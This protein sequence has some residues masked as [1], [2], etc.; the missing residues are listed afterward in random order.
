[1][2]FHGWIL[3]LNLSNLTKHNNRQCWMT[4]TKC[5][6]D[7]NESHI[8][9]TAIQQD[10]LHFVFANSS[11]ENKIFPLTSKEIVEAQ[12]KEKIKAK[13]K[14]ESILIENISVLCK[15]GKPVIPN[16]LQHCTVS[17]YHNYL[18]YPG[19]THLKEM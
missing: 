15:N 13:S 9:S 16:S 18:Q 7:Y 11:K 17:W 12:K 3:P 8:N 4:F 10:P 1:M 2:L 5:W 19:N 6:Q 14:Y